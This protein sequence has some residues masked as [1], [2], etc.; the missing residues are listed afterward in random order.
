MPITLPDPNAM[1]DYRV[2]TETTPDG[3]ALGR[4]PVDAM[5]RNDVGA[6]P[7]GALFALLDS[8]AGRLR[9]GSAVLTISA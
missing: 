2:T 6:V 7:A 4:L 3:G 9:S 1:R 8:T 5:I